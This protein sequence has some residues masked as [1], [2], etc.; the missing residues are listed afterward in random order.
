[1]SETSLIDV[2]V[3]VRVG[4]SFHYTFDPQ[5]T[6]LTVGSVVEVTFARRATYAFVLGFPTA[7]EVPKDKLRPIGSVLVPEPLFDEAMLKFFRWVAEYYCHPLGE[8]IAAAVP[9]AFITATDKQRA[10]ALET[11]PLEFEGLKH[12][13]PQEL[14]ADQAKALA[15]IDEETARP[16]LLH[17]VTGSGKTEVYIQALERTLAA[18]KTGMILVPEIALTPQLLGRFSCRFPGKVAVLHSDLSPKERLAQWE[19]IRRGICTVVIGARSAVFA[20]LKDLG[21][22]IVDE[23]HET[24]FKQEDSLRY[25]A[26]DVAIVRAKA[27][28]ARVILGSATPSLE[29]YSNTLSGRYRYVTL[30]NR[31]HQ[32]E[33]PRVEI[34]DLRPKEDWHSLET[35]WLSRK[36]VVRLR[37]TLAAGQ[38]AMLYLNRLGYAHFLYCGDCAHTWR[39]RQCDVALT[40]YKH[41]PSLRCHYCGSSHAVPNSC[42]ACSGT[43]LET[44]GVGTEQVEKELKAILPTARISRLDRSVIKTRHDLESILTS[45]ASR[46]IDIVIGTQMLA[47]G[48][49][50]PGIALVGILMADATLNLPDF[51]ANERTFQVITQVSGRAGRGGIRGEVILQSMNPESPILHQAIAGDAVAFY[52][53]ELLAREQAGFPPVKRL[54]ML[55]FQHKN[56]QRVQE[57]SEWVVQFLNQKKKNSCQ[58]LGPAEAPL[59]RLK[60][61]YRWHCLIKADSVRELQQTLHL[62]QEY[63]QHLK[64]GVQMAVDVDPVNSM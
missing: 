9:K 42:E 2:A 17:G 12:E 7:T 40:Y 50:F 38:Q 3:P 15:E 56:A 37:E 5:A 24:S 46:E 4:S 49:D 33:M 34:V 62:A 43:A 31:V 30:P 27:T 28:G 59:S 52:K 29:S 51:R 23:E 44:L 35:P 20:P 54:A 36:L 16:V 55:R 21:L 57:F 41:P 61:L 45:I 26:R 19:K 58:I 53:A 60:N 13:K 39:C 64:S 14:T 8:V 32:R 1:M 22:I 11:K 47:K 48:H 6:P 18:G 10:K 25:H 63:A